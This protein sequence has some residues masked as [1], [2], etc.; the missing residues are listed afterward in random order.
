MGYASKAGRARTD[1]SNPEAFGVCQ[2]C[3]IWHQLNDLQWQFEYIGRG[4]QNQNLLFCERCLDE[5]QPQ[6]Q[7]R[8]LP[9]DPVPVLN[10]RP[11][12]FLIDEE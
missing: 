10:A 4:L 5:P 7:A 8:I 9:P 1:P 12:T 11:E 2:R 6:L 3:G